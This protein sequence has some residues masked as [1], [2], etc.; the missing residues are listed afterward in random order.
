MSA[1]CKPGHIKSTQ[2]LE[3]GI[4]THAINT[5]TLV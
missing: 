1:F 5:Q 4:I 2:T 3:T